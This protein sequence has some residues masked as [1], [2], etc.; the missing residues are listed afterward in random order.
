MVVL[1]ALGGAVVAFVVVLPRLLRHNMDR[2]RQ[3]GTMMRVV[4]RYNN[5]TRRSAGSR[6]SPFALLTHVGRRS[7]RTYQTPLGA[8]AYGDGFLLPRGYGNTTDWYRNVMATGTCTLSWK[9]QTY[10][11]HRPELIS[12]PEVLQAWPVRQ[13]I[14]LRAG[15]FH[16]FLW[17]HQK[18]EQVVG[19][20]P[21]AADH[22]AG[23]RRA[24]PAA[25]T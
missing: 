18:K 11:L 13:R 7:G 2:V 8:C 21:A 12:G 4:Q 14:T 20:D 25:D 6:R 15:G 16:E 19:G 1:L 10:E 23:D 5:A 3:N 22:V 9:G 17:L 24:S